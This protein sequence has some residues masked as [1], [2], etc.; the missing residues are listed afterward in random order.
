MESLINFLKTFK[1]NSKCSLN[2]L[3]D[4]IKDNTICFNSL[5]KTNNFFT[6][7]EIKLLNKIV[8]R[9]N[10]NDNKNENKNENKNVNVIYKISSI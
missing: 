1:C 7:Q 4:D 3:H 10:K 2:E 8:R 5:L 6:Q 9:H